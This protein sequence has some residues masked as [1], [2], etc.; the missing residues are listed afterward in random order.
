MASNTILL[1]DDEESI[2]KAIVRTLADDG[3]HLLTARSGPEA[4][5]RLKECNVDLV[6][7]DQ[8]M[9]GMTGL[10]LRQLTI[11]RN[12]LTQHV[13]RQEA[14]LKELEDKY[15]GITR[16]ERGEDGSIVVEP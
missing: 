1:V 10:E 15:P 3:Y 12:L 2:L 11:E 8:R 5:A 16:V 13:K 4:L 7:S 14:V 9:P 6:I